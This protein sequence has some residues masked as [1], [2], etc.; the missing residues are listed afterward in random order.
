MSIKAG[1][2]I[3]PYE[4]TSPLG[5]GGMGVVFRAHDTK[6]QRDVALKLLPDH[7]A[8]DPE[9]LARF[10]REARVLASLN[11]PNIA[12]I[13][14]LEE[15]E[16]TRCIVME[17]VEGATLQER[18][19][20]GP[21]PID[22][23]LP[24]AKQLAE[25]LEAAHERGIIH[26][27][28]KPAN[29]K[30][31]SDGKIKVLDFGLAKAFQEQQAAPLSDSPTLIG[32]SVPGAILGT[33]AYMSPEQAKGRAV[34]PRTD[35]FAFG[36]ILYEML[37][38]RPA[39]DGED[40]TEILSRIL[41]REPDWSAIPSNVPP[42][43]RELMRLCLE[44]NAKNRR[45]SSGDLR[46][47]VERELAEP[48]ARTKHAAKPARATW[49][50]VAGLLVI[51]MIFAGLYWSSRSSSSA[52]TR[53]IV[54]FAISPPERTVFSRSINATVP[55]VQFAL[56]PDG[57]SLTFVAAPEGSRPALWVRPLDDVTA[58]LLPG[59]ENAEVPFWSPDSL[60]IAFFV[61]GKLKKIPATGGTAQVIADKIA[62]IRGGSWG[63]EDIILFSDGTSPIKSVSSS[64]GT[65]TPVTQLDTVGQEGS[66]RWPYFLPG[67]QH[68]L[69]TVR[70]A[71][72]EL[73][74]I[75]VGSLDKKTKKLLIHSGSSAVLKHWTI[76][77]L[78]YVLS[79]LDD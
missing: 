51:S 24:I 19:K 31:T 5:E 9:R 1:T 43:I 29:I 71:R 56:S 62:D 55:I 47:D 2:R 35:I 18:L 59:T 11:H 38:G 39:F 63:Q 33:A 25:A 40:V 37:S 44:K 15:S 7:F 4:V 14:G 67:G 73:G 54:R 36:C 8:D 21:I 13:H 16:N 52:T 57:H 34:D 45:Q 69:Y 20:R 64:G 3:G 12:Q 77:L 32:A 10:E 61:E 22:E 60:W 46:V 65:V 23:A 42:R 72:A 49:V 76:A 28:L 30:L 53:E 66:H 74:G 58:R 68:F 41:Q 75:Y 70:S 27:D 26:R 48:V 17:L 78:E 6:L 79:N 50:V